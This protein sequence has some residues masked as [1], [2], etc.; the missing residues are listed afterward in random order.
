MIVGKLLKEML[1][2]TSNQILTSS[3]VESLLWS[4]M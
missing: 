3:Q 1:M 4:V 2:E